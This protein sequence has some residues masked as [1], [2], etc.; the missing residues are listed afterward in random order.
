MRPLDSLKA[1]REAQ[2]EAYAALLEG[3]PAA[4]LF[5]LT[6][7][8]YDPTPRHIQFLSR[9][10]ALSATGP[11]NRL[12]VMEPPRHSKSETVSHAFPTWYLNHWPD[13]RV[14]LGSHTASLA[15]HFGR[16]VRNTIQANEDSLR[17]EL[18]DDSSAAARW[19]TAQ[20][21]GLFAVG[22]GGA[23]VG[24]GG[25]LVIVDD[26]FSGS[27]AAYS[28]TQRDAVW[29]WWTDDLIPRQE[30]GAIFVVMHQRWHREDLAG[31]LLEEQGDRWDVVRLPALAEA[32][33]PLGRAPGEALW[34]ERWPVEALMEIKRPMRASGWLAE[35][36]QDPTSMDEGALISRD[37]LQVVD[38]PSGG[39]PSSWRRVRYW[40]RA[41]TLGAGCFTVGLRAAM[42]CDGV[43]Y[44]E[45]VVRGQW[46]GGDVDGVIVSTAKL[47]GRGVAVDWEIEPGSA[48]LTLSEHLKRQL[49]GF[50]TH[51]TPST[52]AKWI[53]AQ[54]FASHARIGRLRIARGPWAKAYVDELA[55]AT[56][57]MK[58]EVDQVDAT[59]GAFNWLVEHGKRGFVGADLPPAPSGTSR[60]ALA[61][62][63]ARR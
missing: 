46:S 29:R 33:D 48:G 12:L 53:R 35:Y 36:Q 31:R 11:R 20:G 41:A 61:G 18:A 17:V 9:K 23:V 10:L 6:D 50:E 4:L 5:E 32:D 13:R 15:E 26:P 62:Y 47:D 55:T 45:D 52:G 38:A 7:G 54:P 44:V 60:P 58:G 16:K 56:P 30:P 49:V 57:D 22:V 34:P 25:H 37:A 39:F 3:S 28:K 19:D 51:G 42:D 27:E 24:R 2:P 21:G 8:W 63:S 1:F 40:D 59:S 43:V 14:I